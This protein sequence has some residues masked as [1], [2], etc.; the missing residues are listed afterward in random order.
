MP[1]YRKPSV[2][3]P[4]NIAIAFGDNDFRSTAEGFLTALV[5]ALEY[6]GD[7][8]RTKI[9]KSFIQSLWNDYVGFFYTT[10]QRP[11]E[12]AD[13]SLRT[14]LSIPIDKILFD[15]EIPTQIDNGSTYCLNLDSGYIWTI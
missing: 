4:T 12:K 2:I 5:S 13:E 11:G 1:E 8:L 7:A 15:D 14:Y 10:F 6:Q 9:T 3:K